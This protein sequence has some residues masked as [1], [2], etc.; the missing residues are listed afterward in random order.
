MDCSTKRAE[1]GGG[2]LPQGQAGEGLHCWRDG[3][4]VC[5]VVVCAGRQR[6]KFWKEG[7]DV[8]SDVS[9][10]SWNF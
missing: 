1:G 8:D 7:D 10:A 5:D 3:L 2:G 9:M 6:L 4:T